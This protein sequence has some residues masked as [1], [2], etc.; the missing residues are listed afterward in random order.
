V[1]DASLIVGFL[2]FLVGVW[3]LA[4]SGWACVCAGL[5]LLVAGGRMSRGEIGRRR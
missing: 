5:V 4:G 3:L 2:L 1:A